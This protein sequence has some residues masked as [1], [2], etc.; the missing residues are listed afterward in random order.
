MLTR[1]L[2]SHNYSSGAEGAT[3]VLGCLLMVSGLAGGAGSGMAEGVRE[4]NLWRAQIGAH[5]LIRLQRF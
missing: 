1:E 5:Q 3:D 4:A 2:S